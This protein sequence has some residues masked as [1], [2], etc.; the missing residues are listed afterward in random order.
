[1]CSGVV[2]M[3][4]TIGVVGLMD[5]SRG[6]V[7]AISMKARR[8]GRV[9]LLNGLSAVWRKDLEYVVECGRNRRMSASSGQGVLL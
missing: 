9:G 2:A 4:V 5:F 3:L 1:M 6:S 8:S 7:F